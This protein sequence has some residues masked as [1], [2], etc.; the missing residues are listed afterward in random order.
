MHSGTEI[1]HLDMALKMTFKI[2]HFLCGKSIVT[3][4]VVSP[5]RA[6]DNSSHWELRL[7]HKSQNL[8]STAVK[9]QKLIPIL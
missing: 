4:D 5:Q 7:W 8:V 2:I 3:S 9:Q 6:N 1:L